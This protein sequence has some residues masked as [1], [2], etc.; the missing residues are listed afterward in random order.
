MPSLIDDMQEKQ[1]KKEAAKKA[2]EKRKLEEKQR[3]E[4]EK[5]KRRK[6]AEVVEKMRIILGKIVKTYSKIQGDYI[7]DGD[8]EIIRDP[9]GG[10]YGKVG[11]QYFYTSGK[12]SE[13]KP[14]IFGIMR[15][16]IIFML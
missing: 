16:N 8:V 6:E 4:E 7:K 2:K 9:K 10:I 12:Y 15:V 5:E 11:N 13:I 3:R 14:D 1:K